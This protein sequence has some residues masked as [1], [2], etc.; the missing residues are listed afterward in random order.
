MTDVILYMVT[1]LVWGSTWLVINFQ[2]GEVAPEVSV[3]YRYAI[4]AV[5]LF[6]WCRVR[7]VQLSYGL[8]AHVRFMLLGLLLFGINYIATYSAQAYIA[9]ALN[10]VVFSSMMWMNV[11]NTRLFFGTRIEPRVG[12]GALIGVAGLAILFWP[13]IVDVNLTNRTLIGAGLSLGG[14]L[15]ASL[16]NMVSHRAQRE[17]LPIV[18][19]N[20]WGMFYGAIVT[21]LIAWRRDLPF[22]FEYTASYVASLLYLSIFGSIF[23]FGTYL[24]LLGRIGPAQAGYAVVMF[25]V[26]AVLLSVAFE[27]LV[28]DWH[29]LAGIALVITGNLAILGGRRLVRGV[30]QWA[31]GVLAA[32][33]LARGPARFNGPST[34]GLVNRL[35]ER[36]TLKQP[37][38]R[39]GG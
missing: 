5:L 4:A 25:P 15:V 7:G 22:N 31:R 24:K 1:V 26:V 11:L 37:A 28:V 2:L 19:S 9:S 35:F 18:P 36:K 30:R 33:R 14:A 38:C 10:A 32:F 20:A 13:G 21:A 34:A 16:G 12:V 17:G 3:V 29:V 27:G 39:E 6:A 23:A 8:K